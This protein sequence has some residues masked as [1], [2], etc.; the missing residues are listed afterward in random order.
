MQI[1]PET[2]YQPDAAFTFDNNPTYVSNQRILASIVGA[3]AI[4]MPA[5]M[6]I[7]G[8]NDGCVRGSISHHYYT[9]FLGTVFVGSLVFIGAF[10]ISYR[11]ANRGEN[12]LA[13]LAGIGSILIAIFPTSGTGCGD[14]IIQARLFASVSSPD[15]AMPSAPLNG[16]FF[17]LFALS[18][19]LHLVSAALVFLFLAWYCLVVFTRP[20]PGVS[21][22]L[23]SGHLTPVKKWRNGI[24]YFCGGIIVLAILAMFFF[25]NAEWWDLY[26]GTLI[27]ETAALWAFGVSWIVKGRLFGFALNDEAKRTELT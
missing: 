4:G 12:I 18:H 2:R 25:R 27:A 9:R 26:K 15:P 19:T 16:K 7:F 3:V 17:D 21:T 22:D 20:V 24:Y 5:A 10:L 11:G 6:L 23:E 8:H 1:M 14:Q 13:T